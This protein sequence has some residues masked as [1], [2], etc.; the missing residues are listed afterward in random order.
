MTM[1]LFVRSFPHLIN[2]LNL[3]DAEASNDSSC[4]SSSLR[5]KT[6]QEVLIADELSISTTGI[7]LQLTK[8]RDTKQQAVNEKIENVLEAQPERKV[9]PHKF[10]IKK[11]DDLF[12]D[13]PI[14]EPCITAHGSKSARMDIFAEYESEGSRDK[15]QRILSSTTHKDDEVNTEEKTAA[16]KLIPKQLLIRRPNEPAKP[17]QILETPL[18]DPAQHAAVLLTIQKKLLESHAL[19]SDDKELSK[20]STASN[21]ETLLSEKLVDRNEFDVAPKSSVIPETRRSRSPVSQKSVSVRSEQSENYNRDSKSADAKKYK[22]GRSLS[23]TGAQSRSPVRE[24]RKRSPLGKKESEK[25]YSHDYNKD[26]KER[27]SDDA[28]K[29]DR[30]DNRGSKVESDSRRRTGSPSRSR[31][32]RSGSPYTALWERPGSGSG[33]PRHSWSRSRSKSPKRKDEGVGSAGARDR[34][35]KR[36]RY[37]DER[38]SR[39]RT[40]ERRERYT[41]SPPRSSY[42]EGEDTNSTVCDSF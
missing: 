26:K 25:R 10:D 8:L 7:P 3:Q 37:D 18:Q 39:S 2:W 5:K 41:R 14:N 42:D 9:S 40:D 4:S 28:E 34:E 11:V 21:N 32:K 1:Q 29:S 30:K 19:K 13:L 24:Q 38:P 12:D 33:S 22:S 35:K 36:D 31:R 27:K 20:Y 23:D 17:K 15:Q 16:L 6:R